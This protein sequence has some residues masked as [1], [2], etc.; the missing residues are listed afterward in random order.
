[1]EREMLETIPSEACVVTASPFR[2]YDQLRIALHDEIIAGRETFV[3]IGYLLKVARDTDILGG[4]GYSTYLEFAEG[5]FNLDA[6]S[7]SR[8][9]GINDRFSVGH[10]SEELAPEYRNFGRA[11]L[12]EMLTLPDYL[13]ETF[14]PEMSKSEIKAVKEEYEEEQKITPLEVYTEPDQRQDESNIERFVYDLLKKDKELYSLLF[15][16]Y[17]YRE[18][19]D[20]T[21]DFVDDVIERFLPCDDF[22]IWIARPAGLGKCQLKLTEEDRTAQ[23]TSL[24]G[25]FKDEVTYAELTLAVEKQIPGGIKSVGAAWETRFGELWEDPDAENKNA[26][27]QEKPK[28]PEKKKSRV[29]VAKDKPKKEAPAKSGIK[30]PEKPHNDSAGEHP[31]EPHKHLNGTEV[32]VAENVY[33]PVSMTGGV[34]D[35][36]MASYL[37]EIREHDRAGLFTELVLNTGEL[38]KNARNMSR[39]RESI[40]Y[41]AAVTEARKITCL[42]SEI[43]WRW[44]ESKELRE[45]ANG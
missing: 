8:F 31:K 13:T 18:T 6:S 24:R 36:E 7:V 4:S 33:V 40:S 29:S 15:A 28:S 19:I 30:E 11:K 39:D 26:P 23:L 44:D 9:I 3:R 1:M 14:Q 16:D 25:D 5:E 34:T 12:Q 27:V 32:E 17:R 21:D 41:T 22:K 20:R 2:E 43:K 10:N 42:L 38:A 37:T 45:A 35:A